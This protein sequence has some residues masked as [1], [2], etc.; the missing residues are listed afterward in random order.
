MSK[1]P[2]KDIPYNTKHLW[3]ELSVGKNTLANGHNTLLARKT[4]VNQTNILIQRAPPN[5]SESL[6]GLAT[7]D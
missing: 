4:L 1:L 3:Q 2:V 7:P 6:K 5:N